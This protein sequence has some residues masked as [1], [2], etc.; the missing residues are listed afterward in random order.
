MKKFKLSDAISGDILFITQT[1]FYFILDVDVP[2]DKHAYINYTCI[3]SNG[4]M[5]QSF[6]AH[7]SEWW[8]AVFRNGEQI[9]P[10]KK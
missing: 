9:W 5:F 2:V 3:N 10:S 4:R 1:E 8:T 6:G 7:T